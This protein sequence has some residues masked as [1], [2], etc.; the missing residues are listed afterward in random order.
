MLQGAS[1]A[2]CCTS[3][4]PLPLALLLAAAGVQPLPLPLLLLPTPLAAAAA[5]LLLP[6]PPLEHP[7]S[8][9]AA[10]RGTQLSRCRHCW[11]ARRAWRSAL[12][13][14]DAKLAGRVACI[15]LERFDE[16]LEIASRI[17]RQVG[18]L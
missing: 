3:I 4:L 16:G 8:G 14:G 13:L 12:R 1:H 7:Q 2:A 15:A 10:E 9:E 6:P 5:L 17:C 18:G 11:A